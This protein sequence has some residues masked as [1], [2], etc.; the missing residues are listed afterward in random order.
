MN[1]KSGCGKFGQFVYR[2]LLQQQC[3][4]YSLINTMKNIQHTTAMALLY[5]CPAFGEQLNMVTEATE[6]CIVAAK[7][8]SIFSPPPRFLIRIFV[9]LEMPCPMSAPPFFGVFYPI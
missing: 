6:K 5:N 3:T 7:F 9:L 1:A 2:A 4:V 8:I